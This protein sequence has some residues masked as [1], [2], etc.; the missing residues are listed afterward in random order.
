MK[1]S[2]LIWQ[3]SKNLLQQGYDVL[4]KELSVNIPA[5]CL[6]PESVEQDTGIGS[7]SSKGA[8]RFFDFFAGVFSKAVL[9]PMGRSFPPDYSP[10]TSTQGQNPLFIDLQKLTDKEYGYLLSRKTYE[11]ICLPL[12]NSTDICYAQVSRNYNRALL[13]AWHNFNNNLAKQDSFA[14]MLDKNITALSHD[15]MLSRDAEFY[16]PFATRRYLFEEALSWYMQQQNQFPFI[17]D[18]EIKMPDSLIVAKPQWFLADFTLGSPADGLSS[19]AR[20]WNFKVLNPDYIFNSDGSLGEAG[21]FLFDLFDKLF[22]SYKGGL[23]IDHFIGQVNPFVFANIKDDTS[24]RLY[25]SYDN[26]KLK[27]Y[28]KHTTEEFGS[29][30][31]RIILQAAAKNG[32]TAKDIYAEDL[33]A[34]PE[35]LDE[36]ML[37]YGIGRMLLPQF[38]DMD[39]PSHIYHLQNSSANDVALSDTHDTL[40]IRDFY[41]RAD[42]ETRVKY[43]R[44]MAKNLRFDYNDSLAEPLNCLRMQWGEL[45]WC[46][47]QRVQAFFTSITGQDGRYNEPGNPKKWRL[48]CVPDFEELYFT[49]LL[50]GRA[51]N[52]F[53]AIALAVYARGDD[54]YHQHCHLVKKLRDI[55]NQLKSA[56]IEELK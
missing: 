43:A 53:D 26:P 5:P 17:A 56:I 31:E 50:N 8:E 46:P 25:S 33:G 21:K 13:E 1:K 15:I 9:G 29:I 23:R 48:R 30:V 35:Q 16:T 41:L 2:L 20:N 6:P 28:A 42:Y 51:Y 39:N 37:K 54:F 47:A 7:P 14:L 40:S 34:R 36:V 27:K 44:S 52:P 24:G 18:L 19:Q 3:Q 45:L 10:Y 22:A 49:N 55:E 38:A 4:Q 11:E 12:K 32:K